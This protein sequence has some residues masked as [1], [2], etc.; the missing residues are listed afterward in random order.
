MLV[1]FTN[2]EVIELMRHELECTATHL[3]SLIALMKIAK[4]TEEQQAW[5]IGAQK[6]IVWM[7]EVVTPRP[8]DPA[9]SSA[10]SQTTH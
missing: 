3:D 9:A 5:M 1:R 8:V 10:G 7:R 2:E 4:F 6:M